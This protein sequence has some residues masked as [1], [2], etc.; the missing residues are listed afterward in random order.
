MAGVFLAMKEITMLAFMLYNYGA[1]KTHVWSATPNPN[2]PRFGQLIVEDLPLMKTPS[3][4]GT[5]LGYVRGLDIQPNRKAISWQ[6][7]HNIIFKDQHEGSS[8]LMVGELPYTA[9]WSQVAIVGGTGEFT[10]AQGVVYGRKIK[11]DEPNIEMIE[12]YIHAYYTT[13]D[14]PAMLN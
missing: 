8:L 3:S 6:I 11:E 5:Q 7:Y 12:L 9:N 10:M 14:M 4:S 2:Y 13:M 1:N